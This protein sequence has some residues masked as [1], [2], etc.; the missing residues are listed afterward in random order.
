MKNIAI[1]NLDKHKS[2]HDFE[3]IEDGIYKDLHDQDNTKYRIAISYELENNEDS[4][5]PLEDILDKFFLY[6]SDFLGEDTNLSNLKKIELGGE[7]EDVRAAKEIIGK[8]VYNR[9]YEEDGNT[10]VELVIE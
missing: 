4:Q 2:L 3:L 1:L 9:E 8:R 7:L 6:V 10:Y 5:Y